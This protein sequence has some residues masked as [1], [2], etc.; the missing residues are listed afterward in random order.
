MTFRIL[1][2]AAIA[3]AGGVLRPLQAVDPPIT[4]GEY[5]DLMRR[6]S[7]PEGYFDT[8]NFISNEAG[9]LRVLPALRRLGVRGG[10]YVGVGP[11]QNYSYIAELEPRLAVIVDIR[12]QNTLQHL[13]FK[14]LFERSPTRLD[15]LERLFGRPLRRPP[16][17]AGSTAIADLLA[18]VD[19]AARDTSFAERKLAEARETIR[20]WK[21][22][23]SDADLR[24]IDYVAC[25][26]FDAGPDLKFTSFNRGPRSQ[27][28]SLRQLLE[29]TD[30][31]GVAANYLASDLRFERIRKLHRENR[32]LPIVGDFAGPQAFARVARELGRR[33]LQVRC[34]YTSNVEFYLFRDDRWGAWIRNLRLLPLASDALVIRAYANM[35]QPH[36]AQIP[37]Y[38][39]TTVLQPLGGFLANEAAGRNES[40]WDVVA[41]D[42]ILK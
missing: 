14:A 42:C 29:E 37:G 27:Y 26:F 15:Y 6:L 39:M 19:A 38:Y 20:S 35:W 8:D 41:R 1:F 7:E 18:R 4:P 16:G 23:L 36:P 33:G 28:P 9:Y 24:A 31:A 25:A 3:L 13:Y 40:Y 30:G 5:G 2:I 34:L 17:R 11:D 32:I 21:L 22:E 12:R 10:A